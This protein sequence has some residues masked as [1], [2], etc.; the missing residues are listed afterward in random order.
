[1]TEPNAAT[2][3]LALI[4]AAH[5]RIRPHINRTPVMTSATLDAGANASLFFKCENL[6]KV[7]AFKARGA[8]NAVFSLPD[9]QAARGVVT[10]SSGNHGAALARAAQLRGIPAYIVMPSNAPRSKQEAVKRYG[11]KV[12]FCEPTLA[13]R[14]EVAQRVLQET[15][16]VLIHAF[17]DLRVMAGQ[18]TTAVELLD[19]VADLDVILCPVGGGGLLS[20]VAVAAKS[21][22]P[23]IKVIA[24]EPAGADDAAQSF[25]LGRFV[26]GNPPKSIADGLLT[27]LCERTFAEIHRHVDDVVTV[28]E[29]GIV[30]AMRKLWEV[31]KLV[32]E[33]SGAVA[34]TA[35]VENRVAIAGRKVGVILSGG[36]L[37]LDKL[38]W[39]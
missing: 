29:A 16:G 9:D 24:V 27:T 28:S 26:A 4:R 17:D 5:A 6:Q 21:L 3:D 22:A 2:L 25:K 11:G 38:P 12:I 14:E 23:D 35:I 36:N 32:V 10:H 37:D 19:S 15:G 1:M 34:Y 13:A 7:G 30:Q 20:G 39:Q 8:T 31:L 18:G 33:P